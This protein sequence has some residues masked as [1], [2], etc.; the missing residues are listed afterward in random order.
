MGRS[1]YEGVGNNESNGRHGEL[2]TATSN[3]L[4]DVK[5]LKK[6]LW[7]LLRWGVPVAIIVW[8]VC[9]AVRD[10]S[11]A[12]LRDEPKQWNYL[13]L[14]I[15]LCFVAVLL[16]MVR[17]YYLVRALDVPLG[18]RDA[19]RLGFL[20]YMWNFVTPGSVG[21]DLVKVVYL[22]RQRPGKRTEV[23]LSVLFDRLL[24]L[25]A[26]FVLATAAIFYTKLWQDPSADVRLACRVMFW[27]TGIS[28]LGFAMGW[29]PGFSEGPIA[30]VTASL[31]ASWQVCGTVE[32]CN[33]DV[34]FASLGAAVGD[35]F[36]P[37]GAIAVCGGP[38]DACSRIVEPRR[39]HCRSILSL[40]RWA[41]RR[42]HC[43]W[44]RMVW[45]RLNCW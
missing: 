4:R 20:G 29:L 14:A 34:L 15:L 16:T 8:L 25:Y 24:G 3:C 39:R 23:A 41:W 43:H 44:R 42:A 28:T 36:E 21:G 30:R 7:N 22:A 33:S 2:S 1:C 35:D 11:F 26:V 32:S 9:L 17:W 10:D 13:A 27:S 31:A 45:G 6:L 5:T 19:F 40:C 18:W 37:A 38:V 12:R